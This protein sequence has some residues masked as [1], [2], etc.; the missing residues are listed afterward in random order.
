MAEK[1]DPLGRL[2]KEAIRDL[3]GK[4]W[5]THDGM[6]FIHAAAALGVDQA[7][8]LNRAAI[9]S[10]SEIEVRRLIEALEVDPAGL[11][12]SGDICRFLTD[13]LAL[14]LPDSVSSRIRVSVA[15]PATVRVEWE[16]GECFAYKGMKRAGLLDGYE[17]GVLY[18]IVCWLEA[19]GVRHEPDPPVGHCQMRGRGSCTSEIRLMLDSPRPRGANL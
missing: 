17:C 3:L 12:T 7:N 4:G 8:E 9:R 14:L 11:T 1:C 13:G 18:R 19:L 16:D 15:A 10:M 5:L 2:S 6:W